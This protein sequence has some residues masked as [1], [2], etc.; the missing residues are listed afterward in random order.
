MRQRDT[1]RAAD[2]WVAVVLTAALLTSPEVMEP[3]IQPER[4]KAASAPARSGSAGG[5]PRPAHSADRAPGG[6]LHLGEREPTAENVRAGVN[7]LGGAGR[8]GGEARGRLSR[9][10]VPRSPS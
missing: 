5:S 6:I 3:K 9:P 7:Q 2:C 1:T 4:V 8:H 10:A